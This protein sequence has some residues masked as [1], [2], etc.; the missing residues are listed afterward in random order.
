MK[1][2][3][4]F[5]NFFP[6]YLSGFVQSCFHAKIVMEVPMLSQD[7][8]FRHLNLQSVHAAAKFHY[9][10]ALKERLRASSIAL[11]KDR[12]DK[13]SNNEKLT[14]VL[15]TASPCR[16]LSPTSSNRLFGRPVIRREARALNFDDYPITNDAKPKFFSGISPIRK[17]SILTPLIADSRV[18][19]HPG[20]KRELEERTKING[21]L[22]P[23]SNL[24][25]VEDF[26]PKKRAKIELRRCYYAKPRATK[27]AKTEVVPK[28]K[29]DY[30]VSFRLQST[31]S[32]EAVEWERKMAAA[33]T[34]FGHPRKSD[35]FSTFPC[36]L[37]NGSHRG[38]N[39][40]SSSSG[41][42]SPS[43]PP[44]SRSDALTSHKKESAINGN[45]NNND[46]CR[47]LRLCLSKLTNG[48]VPV[49]LSPTVKLEKLSLI[50][51]KTTITADA[52]TNNSSLSKNFLESDIPRGSRP[53]LHRRAKDEPLVKPP[54]PPPPPHPVPDKRKVEETP[55]VAENNF[56]CP[57]CQKSFSS[58]KNLLLHGEQV[59]LKCQSCGL[60][61]SF[62]LL[63]NA[64]KC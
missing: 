10:H 32:S 3:Y 20:I 51:S 37:L 2:K 9:R 49:N 58:G 34:L 6:S 63:A 57:I 7:E 64:I 47:D 5:Q 13:L 18:F 8:F 59:H 4:G 24:F 19:R 50:S 21:F 55:K 45:N 41:K 16:L 43:F 40:V 25:P 60:S 48:S 15:E 22:H 1:S 29:K 12:T 56:E 31:S 62:S 35:V 52:T 17:P 46:K 54:P 36:L 33:L 26:P 39:S 27:S 42:R 38:P 11:R 23:P 61:G 28:K 30:R 44:S 53:L 14:S